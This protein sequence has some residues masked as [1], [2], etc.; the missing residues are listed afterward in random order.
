MDGMYVI[1]YGT[2]SLWGGRVGWCADEHVTITALNVVLFAL[3]G[4][5]L[6]R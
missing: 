4:W 6:G 3:N 1:E 2:S 5:A